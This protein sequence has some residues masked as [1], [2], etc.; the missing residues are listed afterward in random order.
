MSGESR[1][2]PVCREEATAER[3]A[4][5][6]TDR[7]SCHRCGAYRIERDHARDL[8]HRSLTELERAALAHR[9]RQA[10]LRREWPLLPE[11]FVAECLA[12]PTL[13]KPAE[14]AEQ[15]IL[16]LGA[17]LPHSGAEDRRPW[18]SWRGLLGAVDDDGVRLVMGALDA[19]G[20]VST[21]A[22]G[23]EPVYALTFDG[24]QRYHELRSARVD[25]RRAFMAMPFGDERLDRVFAGCFR[26]AVERAGFELW[27]TD[28]E[29]EAGLIDDHIRVGIRTSRFV[30]VEITAENAGAYWEAG[31][32][33]GLGRPVI[34]TCER[35]VERHFDIRNR[36]AIRWTEDDLERAGRDLTA[37]VRATLPEEARMEDD[38][39][40]GS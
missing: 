19:R 33:E 34:Y 18:S 8:L 30:V 1:L 24:W 9:A 4:G 26:P 7:V 36:Q 27:R 6:R 32:A 39:T 23:A 14:Q 37:C 3:E 22:R 25:S 21:G 10:S 15:A 35:G 17:T 40:A 13:P 16:F 29:P 31:F 2:C 11:S 38:P 28:E 5:G 20:L 12:D